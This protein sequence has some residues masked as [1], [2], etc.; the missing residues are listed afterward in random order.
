MAAAVWIHFGSLSA[1]FFADDYLFLDQARGRSLIATLASPDPIGNYVR[2]VSRQLWFWCV[3]AVSG[4]SARAFHVANLALLLGI[5]ALL[6]RVARRLLPLP[7]AVAA[8]AVVAVHHAADVP[9]TWASGSQDLLAVLG[10]LAAIELHAA[11]RRGWAALAL[12]LALLSKETVV[13]APV[14]AVAIARGPGTRW[15]QA[16]RR[17]WPLFAA[18]AGWAVLWLATSIRR[19][20]IGPEVE[21]QASGAAAALVHL[22]QTAV[23]IEWPLGGIA[24]AFHAPPPLALLAALAGVALVAF[25]SGRARGSEGDGGK[26]G[27]GRAAD[28][29]TPSHDPASARRHALVAGTAWAV[30]GAVPVTA[31]AGIWSAYYYLFS[32]CGVALAAGALVA[33]LPAWAALLPALVVG[34]AS[35]NARRLPEFATMRGPW[36]A[37]SHLN[38]H[39]LARG[40][41]LAERC[42]A[43][44]RRARPELPRASTLYFVGLPAAI[45]FQAADGPLVRWAYHDRSLRSYF[46]SSFELD[47]ARRGPLFFFEVRADSLVEITGRDSL[48]RL[49]YALILSGAEAPASDMLEL[50]RRVEPAPETAYR[51]AWT[52][53]ARGD[54]DSALT[55][56][57]RAGVEPATGPTPEIGTALARVAAGDTTSAIE[58]MGSALARR[59]LD[60]GAHALMADLLLATGHIEPGAI[61]A[62]AVRVLAPEEPSVWRRWGM[63]L[64]AQHRDQGAVAALERYQTLAGEAARGDVAVEELLR[65]LRR[66]L[67]GGDLAQ[68]DLKRLGR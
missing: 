25:G 45:G 62:Y 11:G 39:Y 30:A 61:E 17:A 43:D 63:V 24:G 9:V 13:L 28:P 67:P 21:V 65:E 46:L 35:E 37:Q 52:R 66:T 48:E 40:M 34:T 26:R 57:R 59:A 8:T 20:A 27:A 68:E 4:E 23:G 56:L 47:H 49:G 16:L 10:S 3:A 15:R 54:F 55:W 38:R 32:L 19:A 7:A 64:A 50:A 14:A 51:L 36:T 60:P 33:P 29:G 44:L 53:V 2:P 42:L 6:F 58:L 31:V 22:L 12:A 5:L 41:T 1:P 18:L